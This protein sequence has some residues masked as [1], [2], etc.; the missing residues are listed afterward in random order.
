MQGVP[1]GKTHGPQ[2]KDLTGKV[3]GKFKVFGFSHISNSKNH[4]AYW[5]C[6]CECGN[7]KKIRGTALLSGKS[8]SCGCDRPKKHGAC[9]SKLYVCWKN[10]RERCSSNK[11]KDAEYYFNKGIKVCKQWSSFVEFR[12]WALDNGYSENLSI[13]RI[14]NNVGYS[15][16]NCR[17]EVKTT[18]A[19]NRGSWGKSKFKG[20]N[21]HSDGK[22]QA[23]I[24]INKKTLNLGLF[25][26]EIEAAKKYDEF[27]IKYKR[28]FDNL[29]F[30]PCHKKEHEK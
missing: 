17:W 8:R 12:R 20:V 4:C 10:M 29:N 16:E 5:I 30:K 15:P 14:K 24:T 13:D 22:F 6:F 18:Q 1:F 27:A 23:R 19:M 28:N 25:K 21:I 2:F 3:F 7:E 11:R 9:K 26:T